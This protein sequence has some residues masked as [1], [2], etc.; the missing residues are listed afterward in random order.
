MESPVP[1]GGSTAASVVD[2]DRCD[3]SATESRK[4]VVRADADRE[5]CRQMRSG[6]VAGECRHG[7]PDS[8]IVI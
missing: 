7:Y 2:R 4:L 6:G 1:R 3:R 8:V 5:T